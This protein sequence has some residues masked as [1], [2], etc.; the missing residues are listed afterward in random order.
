MRRAA[1]FLR[2][3]GI[4]VEF[5]RT[6][7][8]GS[9]RLIRLTQRLREGNSVATVASVADNPETLEK[10]SSLGATQMRR[11]IEGATQSA[12]EASH[13]EPLR[14]KQCDA[15]DECDA[16]MHVYSSSNR[17]VFET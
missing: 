15:R 11:K 14:R 6:A 8:T 5:I 13:L 10:L 2:H 1:T 4:E 12:A 9:R 17:E 7:G 16:K 3:T